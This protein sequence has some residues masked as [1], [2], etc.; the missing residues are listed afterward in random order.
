MS[1]RCLMPRGPRSPFSSDNLPVDAS[2]CHRGPERQQRGEACAAVP[3]DERPQRP[4]ARGAVRRA[5]GWIDWV[6]GHQCSAETMPVVSSPNRAGFDPAARTPDKPGRQR[7]DDHIQQDLQ[8]DDL[9]VIQ[10][11]SAHPR[12]RADCRRRVYGVQTS[13]TT[14]RAAVF[15]RRSR[16]R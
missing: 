2:G 8:R 7:N 10:L 12:S 11:R 5:G 3:A 15:C 16:C 9:R 4:A 14:R 1:S 13:T 6:L